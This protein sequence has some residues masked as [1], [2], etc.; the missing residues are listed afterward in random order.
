MFQAIG[1]LL[2]NGLQEPGRESGS[3]VTMIVGEI[4]WQDIM[5]NGKPLDMMWRE[6]LGLKDIT[7]IIEY[8]KVRTKIGIP[9][10]SLKTH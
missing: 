3:L 8:Q 2:G 5:R 4:G 7:D 10:A 1:R 6:G 9:L